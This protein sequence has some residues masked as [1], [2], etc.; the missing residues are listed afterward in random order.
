[1]H[2]RPD[3]EAGVPVAGRELGNPYFSGGGPWYHM[4][5][6]TGYDGN[7]FITN[8][9]GTKR[10]EDYKYSADVL[11]EAIHDWTGSKDTITSGAK[12]AVVIE[13]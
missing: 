2:V 10:G 7:R 4:L 5:V 3:L 11:I 1:M 13:R 9:P 12:T 6:I 8:D